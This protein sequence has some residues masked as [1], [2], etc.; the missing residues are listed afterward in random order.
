MLLLHVAK[1]YDVVQVNHTVHEVQLPQG[2]MHEMQEHPGHITQP[3]RHVGKLIEPEVTHREGR[4]L[5][6]FQ[7]HL[8]LPEAQLEI[9]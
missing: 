8:N 2:V 4:V 5:L 3:E 1:D 7:G 9:H 6:Q